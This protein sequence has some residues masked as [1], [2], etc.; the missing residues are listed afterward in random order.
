MRH[1]GVSFWTL[2]GFLLRHCCCC[3]CCTR[4]LLSCMHAYGC[5]HMLHAYAHTCMHTHMHACTCMHA[6]MAHPPPPHIMHMHACICTC[7]HA[8]T[9]ADAWWL[10]PTYPEQDTLPSPEKWRWAW[11][12]HAHACMLCVVHALTWGFACTCMHQLRGFF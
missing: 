11:H 10:P 12:V 8:H 4:L 7:M 3:C 1:L 2:R 6:Y 5:M 9:S